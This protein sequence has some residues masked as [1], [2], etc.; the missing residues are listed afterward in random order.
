MPLQHQAVR[1][2]VRRRVERDCAA[3]GLTVPGLIKLV[4]Q[5]LSETFFHA[6]WE[7]RPPAPLT[8]VIIP[9]GDVAWSVKVGE[10]EV[11]YL[12]APERGNLVHTRIEG[13]ELLKVATPENEWAELD[14][15]RSLVTRA[16]GEHGKPVYDLLISA[17]PASEWIFAFLDLARGETVPDPIDAAPAAVPEAPWKVFLHPD[18]RVWAIRKGLDRYLL[19]LGARDDDPVFKE[20]PSTRPDAEINRLI[21]EQFRDG[22]LARPDEAP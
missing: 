14:I 19:R 17:L 12:P 8:R 4:S 5:A 2:D 6:A 18:G 22:F 20:R 13:D 15:R 1:L 16:L 7:K 11:L 9:A 10:F 21:T 3:A